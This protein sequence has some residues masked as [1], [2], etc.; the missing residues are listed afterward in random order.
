MV[1]FP[2]EY[3]FQAKIDTKCAK[4]KGKEIGISLGAEEEDGFLTKMS[5]KLLS[6]GGDL[7]IGVVCI[8]TSNQIKNRKR[9]ELETNPRKLST[10]RTYNFEGP[11]LLQDRVDALQSLR[12][13]S[14]LVIW[15]L[16]DQSDA[17]SVRN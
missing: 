10:L 13:G 7:S 6:A 8:S 12:Y 15:P 5:V 9:N 11:E 4:S 17:M 1:V 14:D 2:T 3:K 16:R